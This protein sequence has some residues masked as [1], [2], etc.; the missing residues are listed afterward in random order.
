MVGLALG[1]VLGIVLGQGSPG[2]VNG[3]FEAKPASGASIPGWEFSIGATNGGETPASEVTL[4]EGIAHGGRRSLRFRGEAS[5][6][7][8]RLASQAV[9]PRPGGTY[10]LRAFAKTEGVAREGIQFENCYVGLIFLDALGQTLARRLVSPTVPTADWSEVI[11]EASAPAGTR[12][13]KVYVFLSMSGALWVDDLE[14]RITGGKDPPPVTTV[15]AEGF[16]R[17][18]QLPSKWKKEVGATSGPGG[19]ESRIEVDRSAGANGSPRSLRLSGDAGTH[20]WQLVYREEGAKPGDLLRW[21]GR[22]RAEEVRREGSQFANLHASLVFLD[23]KG[24]M[25]G[26]AHFATAEEGTFDW[27]P[28]EVAGIAPEDTAKVRARLFLSMT[29]SAGFDE[30]ELTRQEGNPPPYADWETIES[31]EIALRFSP[32]HPSAKQMKDYLRRLEES[33]RATC[34]ALDVEFPERITVYLYRDDEEGRLL[35]G[36]DLDFADP[37]GRAVHQRWESFIGHE[38]V[39]VIAHTV[40]GDAKTGILGEGIAV[41]LN[42]Q[43]PQQHHA[44]AAALMRDG[45]LPS[46]DALVGDF[47]A[48]SEGYPSAGSFCGFFLET[49][50]LEA[51][52][53]L[54]PLGDPS[55]AAKEAV[56]KTF[57]EMDAEWRE[58]LKRYR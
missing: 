21:K 19:T 20:R 23:R 2:L 43:T 50:G 10:R 18:T 16:D 12:E 26:P 47:R 55:A 24:E 37:R 5:T 14:L 7:G 57:P 32:A 44:R 45:R 51:F 30:L 31:K 48:Q 36:R 46:V 4:H 25:L 9:S 56:G 34:S 41:W 29:G 35:A 33:K 13:A 53:R 52:K 49:Y 1:G 15:F 28:F 8:W 58:Y 11:A 54:Y 39:H 17:A 38:M 40:L 27:R 42:G 22:L 3:D 6:R